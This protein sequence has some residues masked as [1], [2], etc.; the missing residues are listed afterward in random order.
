MPIIQP[1]DLIGENNSKA[2]IT[3]DDL[4]RLA[5]ELQSGLCKLGEYK[6]PLGV[7]K[8]VRKLKN[9][10]ESLSIK[11]IGRIYFLDLKE[12]KDGKPFLVVTESR[13]KKEG[14][15][16]ERSSIVVFQE[17]AKEFA[18]AITDMA[19]KMSEP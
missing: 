11:A 4:A 8:G 5:E 7:R 16:R 18:D 9:E 13:S 17:N 12:T 6:Y 2:F 19:S 15:A 1:S 14:E 3:I 10:R